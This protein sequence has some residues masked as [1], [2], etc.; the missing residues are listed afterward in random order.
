MDPPTFKLQVANGNIE[1]PTKTVQL[2]F[3]IGDWTFKGTFI[4]ATKI[5][6]TILG[7][8]FLEN[9]IVI[10]DVSQA[11]LHFPHLTFAISADDNETVSRNHKVTIRNQLTI[12]PDQF[13]T[14]EAGI[15]LRTLTST[16]GIIHP[17]EPYS[18]EHQIV[19]ASSLITTSNSK[20]KVRVINTSP[21]PFTLKK[22]AT[23]AKITI[24]LPQEAKQLQPLYPAA[25]R[26][27]DDD[28]T[29][30]S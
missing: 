1:A 21:D 12:M 23:V 15:K 30:Q 10:L 9:N 4:V 3:E 28:N 14:V 7:L 8:T 13:V 16:T 18:G 2:Q 5:T 27:L 29:E 20:M 26:V 6:G 24:L 25:L 22:N 17:T 11:L 19:V